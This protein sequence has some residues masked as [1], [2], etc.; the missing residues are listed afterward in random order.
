MSFAKF[1]NPSLHTDIPLTEITFYTIV[2]KSGG[3]Q[4]ENVI[5]ILIYTDFIFE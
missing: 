4:M 1:Q 2:L 5:N 3:E